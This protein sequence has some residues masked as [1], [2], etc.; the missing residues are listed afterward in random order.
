MSYAQ[1]KKAIK[2]PLIVLTSVYTK[3]STIAS[4]ICNIQRK[5]NTYSYELHIHNLKIKLKNYN[6]NYQP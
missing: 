5:Y 4:D 1:K 2:H 6:Q 3:L